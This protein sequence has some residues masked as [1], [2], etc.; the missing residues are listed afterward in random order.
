MTIPFLRWEGRKTALEKIL[1]NLKLREIIKKKSIKPIEIPDC[2]VVIPW[3]RVAHVNLPKP[4]IF[5]N[6]TFELAE[7]SF[8]TK[9]V[10]VFV[11]IVKM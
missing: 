7:G 4:H 2:P 10:C 9:L 11:Y 1:K 5:S 8:L 3:R 6:S